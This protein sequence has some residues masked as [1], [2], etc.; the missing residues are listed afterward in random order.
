MRKD[1]ILIVDDSEMNRAIL[2]DMLEDY[3]TIE[4]EDG[5]QAMEV[6]QR[7]HDS[8]GLVLLDIVMPHMD[9]FEVLS[10][11]NENHWIGDIPVILV[12][13]EREA[14]R[15]E[16]A[17]ELGAT[18]FIMRPFDSFIV[19]QRVVNTLLLYA[20]QKQLVAMVEEQLEEKEKYS[21][22]MIDIL[23]HIVETRN[24]ESGL[25]VL[26]V[27]AITEFFLRALKRSTDRYSL[28]E[29][30]ITL[31]GNASALHDIGKME[32]DEAILNKPGRLTA[33]E[34]EIM[35][36]HTLIGAEML[37]G[38]DVDQD[39]PLVKTAYEICR[40]HHERY[41]GLGYPDGLAGEDIPIAAQVVALADVYD[42]LVSVRVYKAA[43]D[44]DTAVRMILNGECGKFN[45][46]LM[47]CLR[48]NEKE[49][50]LKLQGN[51]AAEL[52]RQGVRNLASAVR[53]GKSGG[54][55]GRAAA[56]GS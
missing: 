45:P 56:A 43:Y 53:T 13:A 51:I 46:L 3:E 38:E 32:I 20:K 2:A 37:A 5:V 14:S 36:T 48:K 47:D 17:F 40:W 10:A 34:F 44:H 25:H 41:D 12:S 1:K 39:N 50:R 29:E 55:P 11:M 30:V 28:P 16:R 33:E 7:Q 52:N 6:L 42:A 24:G 49:L 19:R 18:D 26:H 31:I 21:S 9:G 22:A 23:S 35:K 27:R 15:V 4:A 54:V 8:L